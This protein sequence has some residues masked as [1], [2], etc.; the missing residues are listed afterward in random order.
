MFVISFYNCFSDALTYNDIPCGVMSGNITFI[1]CAGSQLWDKVKVNVDCHKAV[2][3]FVQYSNPVYVPLIVT[4]FPVL[5][6]NQCAQYLV[7]IMLHNILISYHRFVCQTFIF[8]HLTYKLLKLEM[9]LLICVLE[10]ILVDIMLPRYV[11]CI[12]C[13]FSVSH[14]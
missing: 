9:T 2:N 1:F 4:C 12:D 8:S 3:H 13:P 14:I 10:A 7:S 6:V 11:Y 5:A